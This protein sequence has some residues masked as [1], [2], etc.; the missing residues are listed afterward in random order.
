MDRRY[1][2]RGT[3]PRPRTNRAWWARVAL[4]VG[5]LVTII[6]L[7]QQIGDRTA[8]CLAFFGG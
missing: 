5:L 3:G 2:L 1:R 6:I 8:S 7:Q 4:Y